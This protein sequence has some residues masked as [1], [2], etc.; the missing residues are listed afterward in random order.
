MV[1]SRLV[2]RFTVVA[3]QTGRY[4]TEACILITHLTMAAACKLATSLL[5]F[6]FIMH[7]QRHSVALL[8]LG[9]VFRNRLWGMGFP[10]NVAR[11]CFQRAF[12]KVVL[13]FDS[14]A[15]QRLHG[16]ALRM[17]DG[18]RQGFRTWVLTTKGSD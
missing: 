4:D 8:H 10:G 13:W 3:S 16:A 9:M 2:T 11:G 18:F 1:G 7:F 12:S 15:L 14:S 5:E 6:L 17:M